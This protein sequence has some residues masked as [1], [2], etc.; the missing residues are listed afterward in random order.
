MINRCTEETWILV[1]TRLAKTKAEPEGYAYRWY[2]IGYDTAE[3]RMNDL[4]PP[5]ITP[6]TGKIINREGSP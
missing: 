2:P 6:I 3:T 5:M 1:R 4:P